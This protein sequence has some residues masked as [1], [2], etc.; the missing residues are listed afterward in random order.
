MNEIS[1]CSTS[2]PAFGVLVFW[3]LASLIGMLVGILLIQLI[4]SSAAAVAVVTYDFE[5]LFMLIYHLYIF[6]EMSVAHFLIWCLFFLLLSFK[7]SL[8]ILDH[9]PYQIFFCKYFLPVC[10]L[11][12]SLNNTFHRAEFFN[13]NDVKSS[14]FFFHGLCFLCCISEV[15]TKPKVT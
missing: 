14:V 9:I 12:Q 8:Y 10:D 15:I 2:L 5:H 13:F 11:F 3:I 1:C 4:Y 6:D 7:I